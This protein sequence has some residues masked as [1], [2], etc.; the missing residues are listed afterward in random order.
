MIITDIMTMIMMMLLDDNHHGDNDILII[1]IILSL[2]RMIGKG[3]IN[4]RI[5]NIY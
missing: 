1:I 4:T 5:Y 2:M 3:Y